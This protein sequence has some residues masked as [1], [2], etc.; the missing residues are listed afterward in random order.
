MYIEAGKRKLEEIREDLIPALQEKAKLTNN[1]QDLQEL[2]ERTDFADRFERKI[3]NLQLSRMITIQTAP[4]IRIIQNNN[5]ILAEKI[6]TSILQ[7]IPLWKQ[8]L[9]IAL[10][11]ARQKNAL[12]L[13]KEVTE[14]QRTNYY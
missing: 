6:Q 9:V 4:Q 13:Q 5:H 1:P 2:S 8:Q 14:R 10:T 11:L 7:T 3:H 12:K